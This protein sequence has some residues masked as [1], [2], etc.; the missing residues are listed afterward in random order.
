M[1]WLNRMFPPAS[2]TDS[3]QPAVPDAY[4][5]LPADKLMGMLGAK[6]QGFSQREAADK[7]KRYGPNALDTKKHA[8]A[9]GLF[10]NQFKNPLVLILIVASVI[11]MVASEWIDAGVVLAIVFGSTILGFAQE[12][13]AGNAIEKL[14]SKVTIHSN[15][16]RDGQPHTLPSY[17]VV[18]GDVVLLSAGSLIPADGLVLEAND[19][20][21]NQAVLTGETFPVEKRAGELA[22]NAS[23]AERS[24]CVL[25]GTSVSSGSARVLIVH[26]G[27]STV[28][29]QI[30][31]KLAL[32][33]PMTEFERGIQRFGYLL[34][35]I[36]LVMVVVVLAVNIFMAKPPIASLLFAL[37]LAVGLT[38]ELLPAIVSITLSHGAK[39]M[40]KLG[41]IVR[42]LNSIENLGSMDVLCTDKTGTLTAGVVELDGAVDIDGQASETVLRLAG[43]NARFQTGLSNA[44]DEAV[45]AAVTKAGINFDAVQK[46]DEIPYDFVRKCLSVVVS[47]AK[48]ERTLITKGALDKVLALCSHAGT[49]TVPL[50]QAARTSIESRFDAWSEQ[51]FRV[52]GVAS[53]VVESRSGAYTRE[54]ETGLCFAGFLLFLDPPKP[55]VRQVILD[56]AQR[57]VQLKIITGDNRKVARHVAETVN[58]P[59]LTVMTGRELNDM[60]DDALIHAAWNTSVFAEVD[61][62]QKERIILALQKTGHVVGYMGDG[63]NDAL[64][65]HTADVGISVDTAVDVAKDA[66]DFVLLRKDLDILRQGID[67]GRMTFAN[68]LKYILTT[69][70][71][72]FGNMFSMAA[73]SLF[74]PFL[75]LLASQILLN[76]FLSDIPATTIA[77][78]RVDPEWVAKPR[79]WDTIFIRD[80]MVLFGL[81]SSLFDFL[82]FGTLLWL[83]Q[84]APEEFRTGWFLESLLTELVIALVVR[85]RRPFY[86][87]R[88]G[89]LLLVSTV[90][91]IGIALILPYLPFSAIFGFVPLPAPLMLG[92][93]GLTLGYV[94]TVEAAKK[95]FYARAVNANN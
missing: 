35:R 24:N 82:T 31:D 43:M 58:L 48:G 47:D 32:R 28:F 45:S 75:P 68:T 44:L 73:A 27:K 25:M 64:A 21:V 39:R 41:V 70:S 30:A 1:R 66:A 20:F 50:D 61:P 26:T 37:A 5:S 86:K 88:P 53:R 18:P 6:P 19:F 95:R 87:S 72:N 56:L 54:D 22:A 60:G 9:L 74:L 65:L 40:A 91:V 93:V 10:F 46:L 17:R 55:D 78:D 69:V 57:G 38:P 33:P 84:A 89:N 90:I 51:G 12:F 81:L 34:T 8:T 42:R 15:I 63:I 14:R 92:M 23:L 71:A 52:L 79:R 13:I 3:R 2:T 16:L 76:N 29:G 85:T 59:V 36:M 94:V 80:Y 62:N 49:E 77:S 11:S 7:L 4:W 67:E 83:F